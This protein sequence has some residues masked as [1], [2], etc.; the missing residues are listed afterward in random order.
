MG[1][2]GGGSGVP[3]HPRRLTTHL[4]LGHSPASKEVSL[5]AG[6]GPYSVPPPVSS[7]QPPRDIGGFQL[8]LSQGP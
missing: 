1:S 7:T 6:T 3:D 5:M 2:W 4:K 8:H